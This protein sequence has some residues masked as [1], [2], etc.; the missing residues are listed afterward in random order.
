MAHD[1][2]CT[3]VQDAP[4]PDLLVTAG[5]DGHAKVWNLAGPLKTGGRGG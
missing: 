3:S 5:L 2:A 4:V 1:V